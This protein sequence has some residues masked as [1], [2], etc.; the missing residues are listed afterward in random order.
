MIDQVL[1]FTRARSGGGIPL[2]RAAADISAICAQAVDE[3]SAVHHHRRID[4]NY[5]GD[6]RGLWDADRLAQ[7]FSN[8]IGNALAY[9]PP[10]APVRVVVDAT[11]ED[12]R[13]L[14]HNTGS[15]IPAGMMPTLFDPFRRVSHAKSGSTQGLGLGLFIS[16]QIV[17]A[18]GGSIMVQ[19]NESEGTR[20]LITLPRPPR[21]TE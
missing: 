14:V 11:G 17:V 6:A 13:C 12:V 7:V 3:L 20:F 5:Y 18:H 16:H 15:P 19:S 9:S 21:S 8:L 1:D 4:A 2:V 10:D